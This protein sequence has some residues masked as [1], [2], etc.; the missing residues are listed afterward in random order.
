[1]EKTFSI[2][3]DSYEEL[4]KLGNQIKSRLGQLDPNKISKNERVR[5][6]LGCC[7]QI[8]KTDISSIYQELNLD[9]NPIYYVYA[10]L[11]PTKKIA[12]GKDGKT[13]F[14]A[15][16]G[17]KFFPFYIAKGKGERAYELNRNETHKK[18]R[19]KLHSMDREIEVV[20]IQEGLTELEA[21]CLESKLIDIFGLIPY[22]GRL[23]NLD[24]GIKPDERRTK[25]YNEY[26]ELNRLNRIL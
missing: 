21:L 8:L 26:L 18:I 10:H 5:K 7:Q 2:D 3:W 1:M 25:Y 20:K 9:Q 4:S 16:M 12:I 22:G 17:M 11:D 6:T 23:S 15:T 14:A 19:E 13:T 24:E